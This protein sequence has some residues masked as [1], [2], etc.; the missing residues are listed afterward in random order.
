MS[1]GG[2]IKP[3]GH[4]HGGMLLGECDGDDR[5]VDEHTVRAG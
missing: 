1:S 3:K 4:T 2:R 5:P